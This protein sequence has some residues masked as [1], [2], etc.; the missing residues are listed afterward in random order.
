MGVSAAHRSTVETRTITTSRL[1]CR[2]K[3]ELYLGRL[4]AARL[5]LEIRLG[6]EFIAEETGD[7]HRRKAAPAGIEGLRCL[8]E[9]LSLNSN[10]ILGAFKLRL[11]VAEIGGGLELRIVFGDDQQMRKRR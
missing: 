8:I 5:C 7:Q 1:R 3:L 4:F 10:A 9:P 6:C 11:Q 2:N